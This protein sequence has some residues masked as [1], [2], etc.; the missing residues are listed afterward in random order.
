MD[1]R[2][3]S[4]LRNGSNVDVHGA[5]Y[6]QGDGISPP[7]FPCDNLSLE[8]PLLLRRPRGGSLFHLFLKLSPLAVG[9]FL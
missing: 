2:G 9:A 4:N 8:L 7:T 5:W 1:S 3:A 6:L